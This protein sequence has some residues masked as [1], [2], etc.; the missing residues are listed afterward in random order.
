MKVHSVI[1]RRCAPT[2]P[3]AHTSS[4]SLLSREPD[5]YYN[6]M[7]LVAD[8]QGHVL[9]VTVALAEALGRTMEAIRAGGLGLLIPEPT[10]VLHG[11]W[12]QVGGRRRS[13]V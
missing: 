8:H 7:L 6:D 12:L 11:P 3:P 10:S 13:R 4:T 1:I 2:R 9:H 5:P